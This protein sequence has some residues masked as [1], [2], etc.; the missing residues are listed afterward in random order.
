VGCPVFEVYIVRDLVELR[1]LLVQLIVV[2]LELLPLLL[3][4][5]VLA[6]VEI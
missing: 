5:L 1:E 3:E 6:I 4:G 2:S